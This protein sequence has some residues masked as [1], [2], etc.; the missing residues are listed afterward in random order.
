MTH[1]QLSCEGISVSFG[2][3]QVLN[4]VSL[5]FAPGHVTALIGPNGAGKTTLINVLSGLQVPT[6]GRVFLNDREVTLAALHRRMALGLSRSFQIV[7][8]FPSLTVFE[9]VRLALQKQLLSYLVPWKP[10][11]RF[12]ELT[13]ATQQHLAAFELER[14]SSSPAGELSHG[15]Q[16]SL[17]LALSLVGDPKVLLLDEPLAGVGHAGIH[18]FMELLKRVCAG[19]TVVLVEHNMDAVMSFADH[20]VCLVRGTVLANGTPA[21]VRADPKVRT[22]YLGN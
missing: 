5:N 3:F 21:E 11:E 15:E 2:D 9:N 22:A 6:S 20:V 19:R 16:R 4:E 7:N 10:I 17:E 14:R 8:L 13:A 1:A 12:D 18:K